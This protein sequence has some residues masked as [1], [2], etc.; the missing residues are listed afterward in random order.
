MIKLYKINE[1]NNGTERFCTQL[2]IGKEIA[3]FIR[4]KNGDMEF[5]KYGKRG[6][7]FYKYDKPFE[8][9]ESLEIKNETK[10]I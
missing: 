10:T 7:E 1:L 2:Q 6:F 3:S 9:E 5:Y 4:E 8:I